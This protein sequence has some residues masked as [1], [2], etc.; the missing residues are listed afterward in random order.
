M[1]YTMKTVIERG[2]YVAPKVD[3]CSVMIERGFEVSSDG[4]EQPGFG[5]E[6]NL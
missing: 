3:L 4:F 2:V 1:T 5:G 6:D